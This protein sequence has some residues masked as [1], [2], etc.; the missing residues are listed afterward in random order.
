MKDVP[1]P[2]IASPEEVLEM[3]TAMLRGEKGEKPAEQMK[4]AENLAKHYGM[5]APKEE[6]ATSVNPE[7]AEEIEEALRSLQGGC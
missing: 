2:G 4:A 1:L 7:I 5:L 3:F 6:K